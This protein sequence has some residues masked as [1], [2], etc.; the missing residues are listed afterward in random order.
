MTGA[1]C[2]LALG[3]RIFFG[4]TSCSKA[5]VQPSIA[6][7]AQLALSASDAVA[8]IANGSLG[9]VDYM[10]TLLE[11]ARAQAGLNS[12]TTVNAEAALAAAAL[13]DAARAAGQVLPPL[14][15]LPIVVKDNIN[16]RDLPTTA[17]TPALRDFYPAANAPSVQLLLDAG[18]I[19][20]GKAN[21]HE[22]A[23]G[24]TSTNFSSFAGHVKNPYDSSRI[25]G[26]SSAA[27]R[28]RSPRASRRRAW[29]RIRAAPRACPQP[30][31]ASRACVRPWAMA[32]SSVATIPAARFLS[33]TRATR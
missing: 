16:A 6:T 28:R 24:A 14:A 21:M 17:G 23:F 26:G 11:Q 30:C 12:L 18:A 2:D 19:I 8:A 4:D 33:A 1:A 15:G 29:A 5:D 3:R 22:L 9:A 27:R 31:A 25:P 10:S 20:L 32:A 13:V 7:Q